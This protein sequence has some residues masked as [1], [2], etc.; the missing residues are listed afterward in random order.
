MKD[1]EIRI[2]VTIG[3]LT[4][5]NPFYVASGPTTKSVR[6]LQRIEETG[7][8]AASIKLTIDPFP[9]I[10]RKPRYGLFEHQDALAFTAEKRLT[11]AEGLRLIE[12]A[13]KVLKD[14]I[15]MANITYAGNE[16]VSG[17]VKMATQF[18]SVGADIIELNMCCPNMSYNLEVSGL[19][20]SQITQKTGASMGQNAEIASEIVSAVVEKIDIPLFVK[21]TPEGG[22]IARVAQT[23]YQVGAA[24]VGSTA[25]RL[26][27][28]PID[29]EHPVKSSYY[30]QDEISISCYS[31]SWIKPLAQRDSYEIRK[32]NGP[33]PIIAATG[34]ITNWRDAVEMIM[35][36]GNLLGICSETLINGYDIVRPMIKGLKEYMDQHGYQT[37]D[38][39]RG[40]IVSEVKTSA[41]VTLHEGYARIIQ[42]NLSA[43][44][45]AACPHHV[46]A[47]AYIQ[48]VAKGEFRD[49]FELIAGKNPLQDIC[50]LVCAAP[51]EDVCTL[52]RNSRPVEIRAIKRFVLEYGRK[53]GWS[54]IG[55]MSEPNGHRVAVIGSGPAGLTCAVTLKKA[56]YDV[57][58][59]ESEQEAGGNM[60]YAIPTFRLERQRLEQ[61]IDRILSYGIKVEFGKEL[62]KDFTLESLREL[63]YESIFIAVGAQKEMPLGVSGEDADGVIKANDL[64][65]SVIK[66]EPVDI[67]RSVIIIG[68]S[69]S[70]LDAAQTALRLGAEKVT[71]A[72]KGFSNRKRDIQK[73]LKESQEEGVRLL[74]NVNLK[75]VFH[76][77]GRVTGVE[78]VNPL[79]LFIRDDC[80]TLILEGD[81][82]VDNIFDGE[83]LH[84]GLIKINH[85]T[86]ETTQDGIFAGGDAVRPGNIISAIA[87]GKRGAVSVDRYIRKEQATLIYTPDTVV[88]DPNQVLKRVGYL[89]DSSTAPQT[90]TMDPKERIHSFET[91]ERVFTEEEA[92][93]EASRCLNCGCG[94][95]CQLCK[96]IC[97]EFAPF[98]VTADTLQIDPNLCIGCGMCVQRCPLNNIEMIRTD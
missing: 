19:N 50:G 63:G 5:K 70:A 60:R 65:K 82:K 14:L 36:G 39:F 37:L 22:N 10:N 9:Y 80:D 87:A 84:K 55:E 29:L 40:K 8:A 33:D 42:P 6:Q 11:F 67:G 98:I 3:G 2:P 78:F 27:I 86:G 43:P 69:Y 73:S 90:I 79:G 18:E 75:Q 41:D 52:G 97:C 96:T 54:E 62:G 34:G 23:L 12:G 58:V 32:L 88:V 76:R 95:G 71:L 47:Q 72:S 89:K 61:E 59:F 91:Y 56:G 74:E 92:V 7:W 83:M 15:L 20:D 38:D 4:F 31:N 24:A 46:P 53:Q 30:L 51:C 26:G 28:P 17:W 25:N 48:K 66:Q 21:L 57:T 77:E 1:T 16:G 35:C 49:A 93:A 68:D 44:C 81:L 94:E 64:L 45:K 13:K 85:K